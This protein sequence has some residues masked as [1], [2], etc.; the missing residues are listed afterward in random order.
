LKELR[1][2]E[3]TP[4]YSAPK[5]GRTRIRQMNLAAFSPSGSGLQDCG[6]QDSR[7]RAKDS[8]IQAQDSKIGGQDSNHALETTVTLPDT[9]PDTTSCSP[10]ANEVSEPVVPAPA[11]ELANLLRQLRLSNNPKAKITARQVCDWG[12]EADL[13]LRLDGRTAEE[14]TALI[15]W[16]QGDRF[17]RS[18]ILSMG[19]LR[20]K[21]D[22]LTLK[23]GT[24]KES[25]E[26][27]WKSRE[28]EAVEKTRAGWK[29]IN[30]LAKEAPR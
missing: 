22:A 12:R 20:E 9:S 13:M 18:N 26:P 6:V 21:F 1:L 17:W 23:S 5:Y 28:R 14:V 19:K 8:K 7:I 30:K 15:T 3:S 29:L 10:P 11:M 16:S 2:V 27:A 25:S 4:H 24:A